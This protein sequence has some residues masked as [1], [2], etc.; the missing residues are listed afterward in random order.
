[1][2]TK[3]VSRR[4]QKR[5]RT[6]RQ[7][8]WSAKPRTPRFSGQDAPSRPRSLQERPD[9]PTNEP[10]L[11]GSIVTWVRERCFVPVDRQTGNTYVLNRRMKRETGICA[12]NDDIIT[13]LVAMDYNVT[14]V[15]DENSY[16][17]N[18]ELREPDDGSNLRRGWWNPAKQRAAWRSK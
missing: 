2:A 16:A 14:A 15:G 4:E 18:V 12:T 6:P 17:F 3:V 9:D 11:Y 7:S 10:R 13:T 1:M 8:A 5:K